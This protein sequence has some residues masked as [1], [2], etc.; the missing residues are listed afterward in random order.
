ML[1][2]YEVLLSYILAAMLERSTLHLTNSGTILCRNGD[3]EVALCFS[4]NINQH[5]YYTFIFI[6]CECCLSKANRYGWVEKQC[7][8]KRMELAQEARVNM[9]YFEVRK[10][11]L[12]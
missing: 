1:L 2:S 9:K 12:L 5:S 10:I 8:C 6:G 3:E 11:Q 4:S 7:A